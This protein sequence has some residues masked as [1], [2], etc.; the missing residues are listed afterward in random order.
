MACRLGGVEVG[1]HQEFDLVLGA[2]V[3]V[4]F[5]TFQV[6]PLFGGK[7]AEDRRPL[8]GFRVAAFPTY[9]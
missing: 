6:V 5:R 1:K 4:V 9:P 2:F 7:A 3:R 8:L